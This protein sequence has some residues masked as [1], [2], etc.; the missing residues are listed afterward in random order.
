MDILTI[1]RAFSAS[2]SNAGAGSLHTRCLAGQC[3]RTNIHW[4]M[5]RAREFQKNMHFCLIDY[6]KTFDCVDHYKLWK[7][8]KEIGLPD[9]LTCLLRNLHAGQEATVRTGHGTMD[10][11]RLGKEYVKAVY[12]HPAYLIYMQSTSCEMPAG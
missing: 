3:R 11:F 9:H 12:C 6:T 2:H 1:S 8:L 4:I 5:Q 7:I 10:W